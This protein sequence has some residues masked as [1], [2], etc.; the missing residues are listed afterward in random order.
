MEKHGLERKGE[1]QGTPRSGYPYG[2]GRQIT[3]I[4]VVLPPLNQGETLVWVAE[5]MLSFREKTHAVFFLIEFDA[6]Q[7]CS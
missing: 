2:R 5:I 4:W 7:C 6:M 1:E 3:M